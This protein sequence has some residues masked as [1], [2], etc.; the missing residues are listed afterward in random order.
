MTLMAIIM[1]C[2]AV[3]RR[4]EPWLD[5]WLNGK[6]GPS[7]LIYYLFSNFDINDVYID[8][9]NILTFKDPY[10]FLLFFLEQ[11]FI[12]KRNGINVNF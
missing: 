2:L 10:V 12:N 7:S 6:L 8:I 4:L 5:A 9:N 1:R 3:S 11:V